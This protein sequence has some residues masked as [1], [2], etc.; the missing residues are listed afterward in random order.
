MLLW[1]VAVLKVVKGAN[2]TETLAIT[3]IGD[4]DL[5]INSASLSGTN[6]GDFAVISPTLPLTIANGDTVAKELKSN[7]RRLQQVRKLF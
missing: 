6:P 5:K 1:I 7:L 4:V 2:Y 3:E